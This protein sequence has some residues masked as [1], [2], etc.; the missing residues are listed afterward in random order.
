MDEIGALKQD[1]LNYVSPIFLTMMFSYTASYISDLTSLIEAEESLLSAVG[2]YI[3]FCTA[4]AM[5]EAAN[6]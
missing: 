2:A 6:R 4:P 1:E 3:T 5:V